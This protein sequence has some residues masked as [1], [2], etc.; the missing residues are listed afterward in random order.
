MEA[1]SGFPYTLVDDLNRTVGGYNSHVMPMYFE[2][3]AGIEKELPIPFGNGKR[4]AFRIGATNLFN[5][6]NPRFVDS[7][8]N[9]PTTNMFSDSSGRHFTARVANLEEMRFTKAAKESRAIEQLHAG[10][11]LSF[12]FAFG[13]GVS[14]DLHCRALS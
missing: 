7:N 14:R 8:V 4:V 13:I 11:V 3:N 6:F 10:L 1:R 12:V 9:S 2:T 5:R